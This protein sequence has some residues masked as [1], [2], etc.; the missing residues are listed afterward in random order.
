MR[1]RSRAFFALAASA[2]ALATGGAVLGGIEDSHHDFDDMSQS[3]F[4]T[5]RPCH[6]PHNADTTVT[7]APLWNHEVTSAAYQPYSSPTLDASVG[8]ASGVTKLCLSCHDGTV[9]VD[10][11]GGATG[12]YVLG[13]GNFGD[14]GTDLSKH[15]P[16]SFVY[17]TALAVADGEL[18]DPTSA[19]SGLGGTVASDLLIGGRLEC[20]SCHDV[21]LERNTQGCLGC[22]FVGGRTT[23]SLSL[24]IDNTD[25]ALC[26]TCH[27]KSNA[28]DRRR[29]RVS[30]A[31]PSDATTRCVRVP[32]RRLRTRRGAPLRPRARSAPRRRWSR[33]RDRAN[34]R[35]RPRSPSR[36]CR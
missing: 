5:C 4:E 32:P 12:T 10:S 23:W 21:H 25:S 9:A 17:D 7:D 36:S 19:P 18:R 27:K 29:T 34:G 22:H 28:L 26:L 13:P 30:R 3:N 2:L 35:R 31:R 20:S 33:A 8:Q 15:H 14:L 24:R 1:H 16:V 6:T 11:F